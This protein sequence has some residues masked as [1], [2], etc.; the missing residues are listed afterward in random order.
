MLSSPTTGPLI[1]LGWQF[2][3]RLLG[4]YLPEKALSHPTVAL[5]L[6]EQD[7]R[8][9]MI[10]AATGT[11]PVWADLEEDTPWSVAKLAI[12]PGDRYLARHLSGCSN[13]TFL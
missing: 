5:R 10:F 12:L 9:E 6:L 7:D 11:R 13:P 3:L 1:G 4:R 8:R 2:A